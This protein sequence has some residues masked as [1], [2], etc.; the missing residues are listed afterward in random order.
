[1][2]RVAADAASPPAPCRFQ[3][4]LVDTSLLIEQQKRP[5]YADPVRQELAGYQFR[6]ASSLCPLANFEGDKR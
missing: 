4:V 3:T 6:G 1:M 5:Q 2:S